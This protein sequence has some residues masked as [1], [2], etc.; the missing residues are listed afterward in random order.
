MVRDEP[1]KAA[2]V[3]DW[4]VAFREDQSFDG[5]YIEIGHSRKGINENRPK[6]LD[7]FFR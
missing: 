6:N 3:N 4:P 7:G 5:Q 1:A 2:N